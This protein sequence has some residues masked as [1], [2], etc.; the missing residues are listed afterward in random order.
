MLNLVIFKY[1][2]KTPLIL[3][4]VTAVTPP[5][6]NQTLAFLSNTCTAQSSDLPLHV[7]WWERQQ[8]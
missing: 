6:L 3:I 4:Y 2:R 1:P 7:P 5:Q 8:P